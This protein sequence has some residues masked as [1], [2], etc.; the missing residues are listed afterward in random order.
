MKLKI[1]GYLETNTNSEELWV[2][3]QK[4]YNDINPDNDDDFEISIIELIEE[5][6]LRITQDRQG[7]IKLAINSNIDKVVS[8]LKSSA[9]TEMEEE[10]QK[11]I[12]EENYEEASE[13][14]DMINEAKQNGE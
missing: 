14:R 4:L 7:I 3:F 8:D 2:D 6:K 9:I 1:L 10:L 11:C 13:W 12:E 5:Q